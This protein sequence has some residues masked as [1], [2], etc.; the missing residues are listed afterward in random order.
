MGDRKRNGDEK[1]DE[2]WRER[3]MEIKREMG[4]RGKEK[5]R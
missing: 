2:G 4:D 3:K 5:W 1:R